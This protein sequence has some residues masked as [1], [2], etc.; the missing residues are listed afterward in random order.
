MESPI[1]IMASGYSWHCNNCNNDNYITTATDT[2]E[3]GFCGNEVEVDGYS[4][5]GHNGKPPSGSTNNSDELVLIPAGYMY[6][7]PECNH[8][9]YL[10]SACGKTQCR[11]CN[12]EL[13]ISGWLHRLE[14]D[15]E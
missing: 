13:V 14:F 8:K 6:Q 2:V 3:C 7:C 1:E 11:K 4:H 5:K 12:A 9:N 15:S 10:P